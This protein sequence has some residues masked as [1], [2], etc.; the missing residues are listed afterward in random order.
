[1]VRVQASQVTASQDRVTASQDRVTASQ[2]RSAVTFVGRPDPGLLPM[3]PVS[4]YFL[5]N[6]AIPTRLA[7]SFSS[8]KSL[9]IVGAL[10]PL[11]VVVQ[12]TLEL[13]RAVNHFYNHTRA[14]VERFHT[15]L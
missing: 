14:P 9:A 11:E 8:R 7:F 1:M 10:I 5:R 4:V 15:V 2:D 12:Y 13:V 6:F 3:L